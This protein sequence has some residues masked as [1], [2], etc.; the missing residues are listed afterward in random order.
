M[1]ETTKVIVMLQPY[2]FSDK[3][4]DEK[5]RKRILCQSPTC[6]QGPGYFKIT[7]GINAQKK[8]FKFF[9]ILVTTHVIF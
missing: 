7:F 1:P 6:V 3:K 4:I 2:W 8:S 9:E 5:I